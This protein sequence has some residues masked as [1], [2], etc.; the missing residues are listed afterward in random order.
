MKNSIRF[1]AVLMLVILSA[2]LIESC[3]SPN[4]V[5]NPPPFIQ[6][7]DGPKQNEVLS[8]DNVYFKWKG[9]SNDYQFSYLL[10]ILDEDNV[11][12]AYVDTTAWSNTT[13]AY[14]SNLDE[15]TYVFKVWG[16]SGSLIQADSREF[17][18]DAIK[19]ASLIFYKK[20]TH[21]K[22]GDT[23]KISI[24]SENI[25]SLIAMRVVI[26]F[27]KS[28][29]H[30]FNVQKSRFIE[31]RDFN[32]VILPGDLSNPN[33]D[34][35]K[36]INSKGKIEIYTGFLSRNG[37]QK[38]LSGSGSLVDLNFVGIAKGESTVGFTK[39]ELVSES[40][41]LINAEIPKH[42]TIIIE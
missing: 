14:F 11:D 8:K 12:T 16:K 10:S 7:I 17:V 2:Y 15:G 38:S 31:K 26:T 28:K 42:A 36:Q 6:I 24:W 13:E 25:D 22:L 37:N 40:N 32:Q 34:L 20:E 1:V 18:V 9:S 23:A 4:L 41:K 5:D 21:V 29:V 27:N 19:G 35:I 33:S 3:E 30:L 39:I